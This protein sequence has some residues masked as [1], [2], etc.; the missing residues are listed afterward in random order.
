[1]FYF[2]MMCFIL[3]YLKLYLFKALFYYPPIPIISNNAY[4]FLSNFKIPFKL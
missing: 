3:I 1:M 2:L 4:P